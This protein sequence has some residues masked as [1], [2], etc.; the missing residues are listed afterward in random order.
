MRVSTPGRVCLFGE[1]QDYLD[2]PVISAAISLRL[3]IDAVCT[4]GTAILLH[5]P[6]VG[7]DDTI[8]L[9]E[10]IRYRRERDYFRSGLKVL[11]ENGLTFSRGMKCT[12]R[13]KIPIGAGTSSSSAMIV[14]W[15]HLL[16]RMSDQQKEFTAEEYAHFA[17]A[18]EVL[19]FQGPGGRMDQYAT[20]LGGIL[21]QQYHPSL[22]IEKL[23]PQLGTFVLGDSGEMKDTSKILARVKNRVLPLVS[24]I[25]VIHP[26]FSLH[27]VALDTI[28]RYL[29]GFDKIERDLL[30]ATIQIRD[31]TMDAR[32]LLNAVPVDER[33]FGSLL[34]DHHALL[35][36]VLGISTPRIDRMIDASLKAGAFGGKI[37]GSGGGGC[38]FAYAPDDAGAVAEA[39]TRAGGNA[40]IV[41]VDAGTRFESAENES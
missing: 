37:N 9:R 27:S 25:S 26:E 36:D 31:I 12:I 22:R 16:S 17:Y 28:D 14:S 24:R 8:E 1:H 29:Q 6:D 38:M 34:N 32:D 23:V 2:L 4:P 18:A 39:I 3:T 19:E 5:A 7:Y 15:V 11:Q 20:A 10:P 33:R 41:H 30:F 13:G 21:F 35:R 40:Y